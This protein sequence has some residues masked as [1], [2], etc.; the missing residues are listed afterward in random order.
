MLNLL[1]VVNDVAFCRIGCVAYV[2]VT[3]VCVVALP[4]ANVMCQQPSVATFMAQPTA[5]AAT[6]F[7]GILNINMA[8]AASDVSTPSYRANVWHMAAA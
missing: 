1:C 8:M 6:T 4:V 7:S 2:V 3:T 5:A